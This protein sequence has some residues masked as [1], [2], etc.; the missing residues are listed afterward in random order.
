MERLPAEVCESVNSYNE[1]V[2]GVSGDWKQKEELFNYFPRTSRMQ[3]FSSVHH[4]GHEA[5]VQVRE[6]SNLQRVYDVGGATQ[7]MYDIQIILTG[8][9]QAVAVA[10]W[11]NLTDADKLWGALCEARKI[12]DS[13]PAILC[14]CCTSLKWARAPQCIK[15]SLNVVPM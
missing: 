13:L 5:K 8:G 3:V 7:R 11:P 6:G 15:C 2:P 4:L 1:L 14:E 10:S 12:L 9:D